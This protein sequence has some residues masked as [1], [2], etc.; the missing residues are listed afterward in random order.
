[1]T[2]NGP[3]TVALTVLVILTGC[4]DK[5]D[6]YERADEIFTAA[7]LLKPAEHAD[8]DAIRLAPLLMLEA[9]DESGIADPAGAPTVYY[10]RSDVEIDG[11]T[12]EQWIYLWSYPGSS[13]ESPAQGIRMTLQADGFPAIF[14][15]LRDS[16]GAQPVFVSTTLENEAAERLGSPLP[17]RRFSIEPSVQDAPRVVVPG[18][19]EPGP[20]PLGPFVYV[21]EKTNDVATVICRC[22]PSQVE[23]VI[24]SSEY[25]LEPL[26][27]SPEGFDRGQVLLRS[28]M[29]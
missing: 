12:F 23:S 2:S 1:M 29:D 20:M 28:P 15:V 5:R 26:G 4:G 18:V 24:E 25:Q 3:A 21:T 16:S 19:L 8:E 10:E 27:E 13:G 7:H 11:R 6:L 22:M 9:G 17:G 14:E